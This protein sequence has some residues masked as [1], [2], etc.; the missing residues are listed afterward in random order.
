MDSTPP[1]HRSNPNSQSKSASR[2]ARTTR[3]DE[4]EELQALSL[5][6]AP[7]PPAKKTPSVKSPSNSLPI[8]ELLLLSPSPSRNTRTR[9]SDRLEMEEEAA[10]EPA[11]PRRRQRSR[12]AQL[13]AQGCA[14]PRNGRRLR[15]RSEIESK[16]EKDLVGLT[17]EIGKVRK[18][19]HSG[20]SKKEKLA[21]VPSMNSSIPSP[22]ID[23]GDGGN[24]DRIAMIINDLIMWRDVA[25]S[26]L[27]FG[28][29][30]LCF[31]SSCFAKGVSFSIFSAISQLGLLFLGASF[32]S[33]SICPR[34]NVEARCNFKLKEE[35]ILKLGRLILPPAN[36]A[37]SKT[38]ELFS[39]EPSMTLKVI[40]FL[41]LGAEYGHLLTLRR[42]SA[43]GFF[44]GFTGPRLYSCYSSQINQ[45]VNSIKNRVLET[46]EACSH[47]KMVAASAITAFWNMSSVKTRIFAVFISLVILRCCRQ[48]LQPK[49][50]EQGQAEEEEKEL[51]QALVV[52]KELQQALVVADPINQK[53]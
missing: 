23:D 1:Y 2:L 39:G 14:S 36:L 38:I 29:G 12:G 24:L 4:N 18:R 47:K 32:I 8:R 42:L 33:N 7:S 22:K 17:E 10:V 28:F 3:F 27:W 15:R 9:I 37:I 45:R 19:R 41:L 34:N 5:D 48:R 50:E 52:E 20:R 21:L 30:C 26:S 49:E 13:G 25:K 35:D 43:I 6:L 11:G 53:L 16:E 44:I 40:P 51:Q 46:W 31:L